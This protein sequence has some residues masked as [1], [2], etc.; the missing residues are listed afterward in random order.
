[1]EILFFFLLVL[2]CG[3]GLLDIVFFFDFFGSEIRLNFQKMF[4]FVQDF[5]RQFDI[6]FKN[7]Q[8]GVVMFFFDV[9]E[10]IKF[11]KYR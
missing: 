8:I 6:G 3:S 5:I 1:M 10:R 7:V 4:M 9:Y 11:N 2:E